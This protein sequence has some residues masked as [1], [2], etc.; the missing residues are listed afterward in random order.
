MFSAYGTVGSTGAAPSALLATVQDGAVE[1]DEL[2]GAQLRD[3]LD[4]LAEFIHPRM[5]EE[6]CRAS[7][8][9]L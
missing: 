9:M 6:D 7:D 3:G 5:R 1:P 8:Q 4:D 2:V